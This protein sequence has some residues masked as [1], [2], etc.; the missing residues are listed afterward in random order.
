MN[1]RG[2]SSRHGRALVA[3]VAF[4]L[5]L[6]N[7]FRAGGVGVQPTSRVRRPAP[8]RVGGSVGAGTASPSAEE[9]DRRRVDGPAGDRPDRRAD[10][11]YRAD[12]ATDRR[13]DSTTRC[14]R[15][16]RRDGAG[17]DANAQADRDGG[18]DRHASSDARAH[19]DTDA[20]PEPTPACIDVPDLVGLTVGNARSTW[21]AAGFTGG[22]SPNGQNKRIV[23][24]QKQAARGVPAAEHLDRGDHLIVTA[25]T[26]PTTGILSTRA[27]VA[28]WIERWVPDPKVAG[29]SPVGRANAI[30]DPRRRP[31]HVGRA[32]T[33]TSAGRAAGDRGRMPQA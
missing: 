19:A 26:G 33:T 27:P 20:E 3:A 28:Q 15:H 8:P 2:V 21:T 5:I 18:S 12:T 17:G 23:T 7:P 6:G 10:R 11:R 22:F 31:P 24:G 30:F 16:T 13:R 25:A 1:A 29:S 14:D 32:G 9:S 4:A